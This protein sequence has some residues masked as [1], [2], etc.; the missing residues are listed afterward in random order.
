[1]LKIIKYTAIANIDES[2]VLEHRELD[3]CT[4]QEADQCIV[5]HPEF[6]KIPVWAE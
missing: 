4:E 5:D 1:M 2:G 3:F 6:E